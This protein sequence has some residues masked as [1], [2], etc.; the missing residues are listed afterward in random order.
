MPNF[1][2]FKRWSLR[3]G[4]E[5]GKLESLVR[6]EIVPHFKKL[7]GCLRLGLLH[8]ADTRSYLALQYWSSRQTWEET[9]NSEDYADWYHQYEPILERWNELVTFEQEWA[10]EVVEL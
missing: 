2:T 9:T 8:I 1:I 4:V 6:G 5:Q 7:P 3:D 10:C